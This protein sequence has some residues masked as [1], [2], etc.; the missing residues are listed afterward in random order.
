MGEPLLRMRYEL[1]VTWYLF[2][3]SPFFKQKLPS[4]LINL[5]IKIQINFLI[6]INK[7]N[8]ITS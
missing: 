1:K 2:E 4:K 5:A 6:L 8:R 3:A 7:F